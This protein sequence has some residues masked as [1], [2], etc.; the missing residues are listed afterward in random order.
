MT[1]IRCVIDPAIPHG[2]REIIF[3]WPRACT[4]SLALPNTSESPFV[5]TLH[6][7]CA[8]ALAGWTTVSAQIPHLHCLLAPGQAP[9]LGQMNV[10]AYD[11]P[12][13]SVTE[14][15]ARSASQ[16]TQTD[17]RSQVHHV[18]AQASFLIPS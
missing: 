16:Q 6:A 14:F 17:L 8:M 11:M 1:S 3:A 5:P 13:G 4:A 12:K 15:R 2:Y 10:H 9:N 18:A 7:P